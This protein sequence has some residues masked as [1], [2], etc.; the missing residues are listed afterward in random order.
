MSTRATSTSLTCN[1]CTGSRCQLPTQFVEC[2]GARRLRGARHLIRSSAHELIHRC[3]DAVA[4]TQGDEL[5]VEVIRLDVAGPA[6]HALPRRTP[7]PTDTADRVIV[8]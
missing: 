6:Q 7:H 8:H 3:R 4:R 5:T 1:G 2:D